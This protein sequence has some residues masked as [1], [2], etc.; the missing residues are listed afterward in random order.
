MTESLLC[1][2]YYCLGTV[3]LSKNEMWNTSSLKRIKVKKPELH[4]TSLKQVLTRHKTSRLLSPHI[5][6]WAS[7][8]PALHTTDIKLALKWHS[9]FIQKNTLNHTTV[10]I[11]FIKQTLFQHDISRKEIM[12]CHPWIAEGVIQ[13]PE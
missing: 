3:C 6:K 12:T 11:C 10:I 2:H 1:Q 9:M 7:L 4:K 5:R 13:N 8:K